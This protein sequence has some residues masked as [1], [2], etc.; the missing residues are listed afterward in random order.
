[1][2]DIFVQIILDFFSLL[3]LEKYLI[4]VIDLTL[5]QPFIALLSDFVQSLL[6]SDLLWVVEFL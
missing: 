4:L 1:M 3:L 5:G 2:L 6:K